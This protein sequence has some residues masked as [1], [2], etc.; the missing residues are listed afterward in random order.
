MAATRS[1]KSVAIVIGAIW[2][3]LSACAPPQVQAAVA[4]GRACAEV[5]NP[6]VVDSSSLL[7]KAEAEGNGTATPI[8]AAQLIRPEVR[9]ITD[10]GVSWLSIDYN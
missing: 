1:I 10:K 6:A 3:L 8:Q 5:I 2:M 7:A 4:Q 9:L